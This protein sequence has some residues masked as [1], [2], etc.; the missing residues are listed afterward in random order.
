MSE[1]DNAALRSENEERLPLGI[2]RCLSAILTCLPPWI[3]SFE[4]ARISSMK[5][6]PIA[7]GR[8]YHL[9]HLYILCHQGSEAQPAKEL[10]G[11]CGAE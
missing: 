4:D 11:D 8:R 1:P 5:P 2:Y 9:S 6:L 3:I 7:G 10:A